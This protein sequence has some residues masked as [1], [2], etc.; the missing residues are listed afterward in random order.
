MAQ[1]GTV[2][3]S[4][5]SWATKLKTLRNSSTSSSII[6]QFGNRHSTFPQPC[7]VPQALQ[8]LCRRREKF[9]IIALYLARLVNLQSWKVKSEN[10]IYF[11]KFSWLKIY[12]QHNLR[13]VNWF[14][15]EFLCVCSLQLQELHIDTK[16][17]VQ[18]HYLNRHFH[19]PQFSDCWF[20]SNKIKVSLF[21][22]CDCC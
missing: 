3:V 6:R 22:L 13:F 9:Q 8:Q 18:W 17:T 12:F 11:G 1:T 19:K 14:G 4:L 5:S 10:S 20:P 21:I 16:A 15:L 2:G 7:S